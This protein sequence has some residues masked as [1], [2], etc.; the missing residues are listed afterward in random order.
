MSCNITEVVL[1]ILCA[2]AF[3]LS[4][5]IN[6]FFRESPTSLY[7]YD[8]RNSYAA[9]LNETQ[10]L[11]R[12]LCKLEDHCLSPATHAISTNAR[13]GLS[14]CVSCRGVERSHRGGKSPV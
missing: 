6:Q 2:S 7:A 3:Y 14:F 12:R 10:W 11:T 4:F 5:H 9:L 8:Q 1:L 13:P